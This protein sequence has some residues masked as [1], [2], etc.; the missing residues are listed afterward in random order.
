MAPKQKVQSNSQA[1]AAPLQEANAPDPSQE[2]KKSRAA[3]AHAQIEQLQGQ[4][5]VE[6]LT[7]S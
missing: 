4:P 6:K 3:A 1:V 2:G 7:V 5:E